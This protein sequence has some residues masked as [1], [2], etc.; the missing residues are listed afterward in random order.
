VR[1][2]N[3]MVHKMLSGYISSNHSAAYKTEEQVAS[4]KRMQKA[5]DDPNAWARVERLK[6]EKARSD[7]FVQHSLVLTGNIRSIDQALSS[8]GD[9]L[10]GASEL[11]ILASDGSRSRE[12]RQAMAQQVDQML[13][14]LVQQG[15]STFDGKAL[16]G[17]MQTEVTPFVVSRNADGRIDGVAYEGSEAA[18]R[19]E[20]AEGDAVPMHFVGDD[21]D[22]GVFVS[23]KADSFAALIE[24]R[25]L[26]EAGENIA[27]TG[28]QGRVDA[29]FE[30]S[31]MA[32]AA[33]GGHLER[34]KF[35]DTSR[36]AQ[37]RRLLET[38]D[39]LEGLDVAEAVTE[40]SAKQT[41]YQAALAVSS[42][43][44]NMSL[45]KYI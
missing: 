33:A 29:A 41:A 10:K 5:S 35:A 43:T 31:L 40:L 38:I 36:D 11:A 8:V 15:N 7:Q 16:F 26:L 30:Q 18:S 12:D 27:G 22:R 6:M 1:V 17:G 23:S 24:L 42:Q 34:I 14:Q 4:G 21:P 2:T 9:V 28:V 44:M 19:L 32:R 13:E 20:I 37:E 25:D 3:Q 45:L 39:D